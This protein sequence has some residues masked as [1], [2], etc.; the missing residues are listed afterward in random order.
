MSIGL[1]DYDMK[2]Y[3]PCPFNLEIMKLANYYKQH[4]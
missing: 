1:Y 2:W 3:V 4:N